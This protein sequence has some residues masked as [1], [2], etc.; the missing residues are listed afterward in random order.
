MAQS[1]AL[2]RERLPRHVA[3][4]MDGNGRWAKKRLLPRT[5]GH[6]AGMETLREIVRASSDHGIEVLTLFAFSTENWSRPEGE[7]GFLMQLLVEFFGREI[8]QLHK[9]GVRIRILGDLDKLPNDARA[10][11]LS[12]IA[13]TADNRGLQ[14]NIALNYGSRAELAFAARELAAAC[15]RGEMAP[16]Q[17]TERDISERLFTRG[18]PDVDLLI[19]TSGEMRLSNFLLFQCAYAEMIFTEQLWPDFTRAMYLE[20]LLR[21]T[22]R[23]RRF[24]GLA[25]S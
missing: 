7:V 6:R 2:P 24:G 23:E 16:E 13:R 11:A 15:V 5:A 18:Q 10:A 14:L 17:I 8:E 22:R 25:K 9:E 3:I 21:Y 19:R 12:G 20:L 1:E 4:I